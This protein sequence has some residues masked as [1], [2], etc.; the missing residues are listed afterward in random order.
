MRRNCD[1]AQGIAPT[2]SDLCNSQS[3]FADDIETNFQAFS[4]YDCFAA[5]WFMMNHPVLPPNPGPGQTGAG[6]MNLVTISF[7]N[8]NV[9]DCSVNYCCCVAH[10]EGPD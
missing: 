5:L 2:C 1:P 3:Q 4:G 8:C 7:N 9:T 6:E 10:N